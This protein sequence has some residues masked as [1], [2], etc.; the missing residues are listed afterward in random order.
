LDY[1][2]SGFWVCGEGFSGRSWFEF[3][4]ADEGEG[5]V[6]NV[7]EGLRRLSGTDAAGVFLEGDI[8]DVEEPIFDLPMGAGQRQKVLG[9][10]LLFGDRGYRV[11]DLPGAKDFRLAG[12]FDPHD[13]HEAGPIAVEIGRQFAAHGDAADFDASM[14][15]VDIL[16]AHQIRRIDGLCALARLAGE[17]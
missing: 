3:S 6:A 8:A 4:L 10:H 13:P 1:A 5:G 14:R 15:L 2:D 16:G 11:D 9:A 17:P 12:A 7:D